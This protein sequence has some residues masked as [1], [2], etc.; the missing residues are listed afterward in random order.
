MAEKAE[1]TVTVN[2]KVYKLSELS[3]E[4]KKQIVNINTVD[5]ELRRLQAQVAIHQTARNT[6]QRALVDAL[7]KEDK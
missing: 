3:E 6:Y 5:G 4:C 1:Q 7:P 2:D